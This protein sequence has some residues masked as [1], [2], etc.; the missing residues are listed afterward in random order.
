[1]SIRASAP[2]IPHRLL[3]QRLADAVRALSLRT[4]A[5]QR[6]LGNPIIRCNG[7]FARTSRPVRSRTRGTREQ[8]FEPAR[9]GRSTH[10]MWPCS[11]R[12]SRIPQVA[13]DSTPSASSGTRIIDCCWGVAAGVA[14]AHD[15]RQLAARIARP[16]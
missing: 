14:L 10:F 11:R 16:A 5:R 2:V 6:F 13:D 3:G 9:D 7:E 12:H 8:V 1:M 15:D 4:I